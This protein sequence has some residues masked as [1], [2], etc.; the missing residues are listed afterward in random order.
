MHRAINLIRFEINHL[1]QLPILN[2]DKFNWHTT[3]KAIRSTVNRFNQLI[4]KQL[5]AAADEWMN[6][7][8]CGK[9]AA[10]DLI[11]NAENQWF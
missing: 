6:E 9:T 5:T 4:T 7:E 10:L 3:I 8:T 2:A 1:F 11:E